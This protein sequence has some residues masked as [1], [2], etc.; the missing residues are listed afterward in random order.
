MAVTADLRVSVDRDLVAELV[1]V[2]RACC[3]FFDIGYD[4]SRN[5]LS[6]AVREREHV[7]A[8]DVV[9]EA[10]GAT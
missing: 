10:L 4:D 5:V 6:I 7:P 3:P 9:A 1:D 8:L 2:E